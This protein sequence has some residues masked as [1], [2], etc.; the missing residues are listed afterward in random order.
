MVRMTAISTVPHQVRRGSGAE[1][2]VMGRRI[3]YASE[4]SVVDLNKDGQVE[5]VLTTYGLPH[6][7]S[8]L[9]SGYLMV[10]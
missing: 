5:L 8:T 6:N 9:P 4:I 2:Y 3:M 10:S 1:I 7:I